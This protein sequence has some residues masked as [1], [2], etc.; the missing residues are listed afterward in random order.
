MGLQLV[1]SKNRH[2]YENFECRQ[3]LLGIDWKDVSVLI[4]NNSK[5]D[6]VDVIL[7]LSKAGE[8]VE[9]VIYISQ[10]IN[11]LYYGI[12]AGA[13]ADI[14]D[15]EG[16]LLEEE[17]LNYLVSDYKQTGMTIKPPSDD[18]ET[19][20]KFVA[21]VSKE[22]AD[23]L[24]KLVNNSIWLQTLKSSVESVETA[25]VRTDQANVS[26]VEMFNKTSEIID[27]LQEG[28]M[29]TTE[30]IEKLSKYLEQVEQTST[31]KSMN[32][33]DFPTFQVPNTVPRVLYIRVY[34]PC[35]YLFSFVEA[36]QHYLKMT[37]QISSKFLIAVP[38]LKQY[39]K[40][41]ENLARLSSE[42]INQR[43]IQNQELFVTHEP[44][45]Q[46]LTAFFNMRADLYIVVDMMFGSALLAGAKV[47]QYSAVTGLSDIQRYG[48]DTK[49]C[50]ISGAGLSSNII[51]P[52]ISNYAYTNSGNGKSR[53]P[54]NSTVKRTKYFEVCKD[55]GYKALD[56]ALGL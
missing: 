35:K 51:I 9:K 33:F 39:I 28:Q 55:K 34:S 6:E 7:E 13:N 49:R 3:S 37:K 41:Y 17:V 2:D 22:S 52:T 4:F 19:I 27:N 5:D 44:K 50:I 10:Q 48:V 18:V 14:Y 11:A 20:S 54:A 46:I 16:M 24:L 15:D 21:A 1:I 23:S 56:T 45:S 8:I 25:L 26:M 43:G 53:V 30:E 47:T 31:V 42:T 40:K 36:Y 29:R 38:K 32:I 12:F